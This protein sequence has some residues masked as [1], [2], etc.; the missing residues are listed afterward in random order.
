MKQL[1]A[2]QWLKQ[3]FDCEVSYFIGNECPIDTKASV[4]ALPYNQEWRVRI[5]WL[6]SGTV[7]VDVSHCISGEVTLRDEFGKW[8]DAGSAICEAVKGENW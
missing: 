7:R 5:A 3:F 1:L 6:H 2:G 8:E 4:I